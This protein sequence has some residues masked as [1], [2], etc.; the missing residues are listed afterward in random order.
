VCIKTKIQSK[1]FYRWASEG[2]PSN[3]VACEPSETS[4]SAQSFLNSVSFIF[5]MI[6]KLLFVLLAH[7]LGD[8]AFQSKFIF[9]TKGKMFYSLFVHSM[10]YA[11]LVSLCF[12]FLGVFAFWKFLAVLTAHLVIDKWKSSIK[13]AKKSEGIYLYVDQAL[14]IALDVALFFL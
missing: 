3:D 6:E 10:I 12:Y 4:S 5:A 1:I 11:L 7:Y 14:H 13:D 8:Y 2:T 9:D